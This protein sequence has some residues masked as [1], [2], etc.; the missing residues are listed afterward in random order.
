[1]DALVRADLSARTTAYASSLQAGWMSINDVRRKENLPRIDDP[2]ADIP[3]VPL[4]SV[5]L[6]AANLSAEMERVKMAQMLVQ[7]GFSPEAVAS[8]FG[9][10]AI[11]HTGVPSTQLQPVSMINPTDPSSVYGVP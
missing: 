4:A 8:A 2:S 11:P 1:M 3:R 10:P 5:N 7:V 6:D 9:L